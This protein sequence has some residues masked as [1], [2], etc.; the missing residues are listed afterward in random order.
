MRSPQKRKT[1]TL[2]DIAEA[3]G[4]S[5]NTVSR[6]LR[7][8]EDI[9]VV[10]RKKIKKTALEM[11]HVNNM[12][13]SS[14][15]LGYTNTIAVIISD[16]SNPYF[17]IT[18]KEIEVYARQL[19]FTTFIINTNEDNEAELEAI[20][21]ALN[22]NV[23]GIILCPAQKSEKNIQYLKDT[24]VPFVLLGRRFE[25]ID[26]DYVVSNDELGG[27]QAVSY[28]LDKGHTD[29]LM[30]SGP[31]YLSSARERLEG[32]RR[33]ITERNL[34]VNEDLIWEVPVITQ[35]FDEIMEK[36][37]DRKVK[38]S[39]IFAYSDIIAWAAW[40][41]LNKKGYSIGRDFSLV[42]YDYIQSRL[43]IPFQLSTINPN[44]ENLSKT[45]VEILLKRIRGEQNNDQYI[46]SIGNTILIEGDTVEPFSNYSIPE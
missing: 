29:I 23:D 14:L 46:T 20:Q 40:S 10:T 33:A 27:Y 43:V 9:S 37:L 3:T 35:G 18:M 16:V 39:A 7:D 32:Y 31:T 30:L 25:H 6:A 38:F 42:G 24:G 44:K 22:K 17:A 5:I 28:L 36:I 15:R 41:F 1:A 4:Y 13:A 11:R 19:G 8:K 2:K 26:T 21:A 45:A 12:I 34:K